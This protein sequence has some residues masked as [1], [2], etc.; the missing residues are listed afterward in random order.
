MTLDVRRA[1]ALHFAPDL[2]ALPLASRVLVQSPRSGGTRPLVSTL[3]L[4]GATSTEANLAIVPVG[5]EGSISLASPV[6]VDVV[7]DLAGWFTGPSAASSDEGL[8]VPLAALRRYGL[9]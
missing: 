7:V 4:A 9:T 8:L 1:P 3:N 2:S 5:R 6:L